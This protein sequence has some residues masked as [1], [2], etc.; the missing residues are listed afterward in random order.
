[1]AALTAVLILDDVFMLHEVLL[2]RLLPMVPATGVEA[3]VYS[4]YAL[5][6]LAV[7]LAGGREIR[8][9]DWPTWLSASALLGLSASADLLGQVLGFG[10]WLLSPVEDTSKLL[11]VFGWSAYLLGVARGTWL[12]VA[13]ILPAAERWPVNRPAT[14]PERRQPAPGRRR[15]RAAG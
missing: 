5:L 13:V 1:L 15:R 6:G 10:Q 14:G 4:A 2:P 9:T 12:M 8:G 11:G 3:A 7:L